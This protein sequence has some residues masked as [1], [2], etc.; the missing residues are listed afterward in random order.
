VA[1]ASDLMDGWLYAN[2]GFHANFFG[3]R[4][5]QNHYQLSQSLYGWTVYP[6]PHLRIVDF[7][8][9]EPLPE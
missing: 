1:I 9:V 8:S 6:F 3:G 4:M 5:I 2:L 7:N